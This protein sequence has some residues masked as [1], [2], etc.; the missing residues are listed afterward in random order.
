M[1]PTPPGR[2]TAIVAGC[3]T[4]FLKAWSH[5]K[6]LGALDLGKAAVQELLSKAELRPAVVD[7]M[8]FGIVVPAVKMP[9]IAREIALGA[10]IPAQVPAFTVSL[11]C[12]SSLVAI[13][14]G[15]DQIARGVA[16]VVVAGG[17]DSLSDVPLTFHPHAR[18]LF[19]KL[20]RSRTFGERLSTVLGFKFRDFIPDAPALEEPSTGLSMG[21][22]AEQMA[23]INH[24]SR[25]EQD[26]FALMSHQRA[27]A[28]HRN[29]IFK[30]EIAPV[31][32][33]RDQLTIREDNIIRSETSMEVMAKLKPVFDK[34]YGTITAANSSP[35]TDG[36]AAVLLM[37]EEKA[38]ALGYRPLAFLRSSAFS[39]HSPKDQ[40]LMG[41][42]YATPAALDRAGLKWSDLSV[43]EMH[44][45]FAASV[46][47]TLKMFE[48]KQW[49]QEKLNR[50]EPIG[51][52]DYAKLNRYGGSIAIGHPFAAT[53]ARLVTTLANELQRT[54]SAFGLV[55]ACAAGGHGAAMVLERE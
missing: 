38:R 1:Y 3:R 28:A 51:Q 49:A 29:G 4:P 11:A 10:G 2:R 20:N 35:L 22:S 39:A 25:H 55:T 30:N 54:N 12:I 18:N 47:A 9:N 14:N 7:Q 23:Q 26:E 32:L 45:A 36:A 41:P 34:R 21:Q 40:M 17:V 46:L 8:I 19:L 16:D 13:A 44:E 52:I 5:F 50:S 48:S 27:A 6:H 53:G 31:Y 43:I 24:I 37:S 15:S 42:A 33:T